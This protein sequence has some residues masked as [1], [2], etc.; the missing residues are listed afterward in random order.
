MEA[1][2]ASPLRAVEVATNYQHQACPQAQ[3]AT[4]RQPAGG[5]QSCLAAWVL[6][7]LLPQSRELLP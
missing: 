1:H 2:C 5:L 7:Q 6:V 3:D 4:V